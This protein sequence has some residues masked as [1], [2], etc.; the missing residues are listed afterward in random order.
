[1]SA[2]SKKSTERQLLEER[3]VKCGH[4]PQ[5]FSNIGRT[6]LRKKV[7]ELEANIAKA[8]KEVISNSDN[9]EA[10]AVFIKQRSN[11]W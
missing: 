1:M 8:Q 10:K 4:N 3:V 6:A 9:K 11:L 5:E 2:P 7:Y